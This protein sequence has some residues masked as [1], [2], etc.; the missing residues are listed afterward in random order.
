[1]V[2]EWSFGKTECLMPRQKYLT[3]IL[4][5]C[6]GSAVE[7]IYKIAAFLTPELRGEQVVRT[8]AGEDRVRIP[9]GK[10]RLRFSDARPE[11]SMVTAPA[12]G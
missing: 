7:H 11:S 2:A 8:A 4:A 10:L 9:A 3:A 5:G 12:H 6:V 1:M